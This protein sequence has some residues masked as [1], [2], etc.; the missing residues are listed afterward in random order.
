[1]KKSDL[2]EIGNNGKELTEK[3]FNIKNLISDYINFYKEVYS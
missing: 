1:M 2:E 3:K